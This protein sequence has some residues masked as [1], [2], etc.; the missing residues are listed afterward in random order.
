[1]KFLRPIFAASCFALLLLVIAILGVAPASS[2]G[3]E[4]APDVSQ[5]ADVFQVTVT[6]TVP[7]ESP[8]STF[9]TTL[10][11]LSYEERILNSPYGTTEY[12]LRL[13]E[14]WELRA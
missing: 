1:M 14:G 9:Q 13:P 4:I 6:P 3:M 2:Q 8:S 12:T 5:Y 10:A 11:G 7:I